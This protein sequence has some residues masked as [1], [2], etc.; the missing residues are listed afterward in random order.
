MD[1]PIALDGAHRSDAEILDSIRIA[2]DWQ[3]FYQLEVTVI[4]GTVT[5]GG[6]VD[7]WS[8]RRNLATVLRQIDGVHDVVNRLVVRAPPI[9]DM[10]VRIAI[11]QALARRAMREARRID[12]TIAGT[13]VTV[14]GT[15]GSAGERD[16]VLGAL[17]G[18]PGVESV[19]DQLQILG[20]HPVQ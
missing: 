16:A 8:E 4:A 14:G 12:L 10:T 15:V 13:R 20:P 18:T 5:I 9:G 1:T 2:L 6:K 17:I 11:E 3:V 7:S 19:D